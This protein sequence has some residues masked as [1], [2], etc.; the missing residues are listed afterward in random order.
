[1]AVLNS[2]IIYSELIEQK[3]YLPKY[4]LNLI[5][6]IL[7]AHL[8]LRI[9]PGRKVSD[10]NP[11]RHVARHYP[12][13]IIPSTDKKK[14]PQKKCHIHAITQLGLEM[15]CVKIQGTSV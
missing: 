15:K 9:L 11:N 7:E 13:I 10:D 2:E 12:S 14:N 5:H 4:R 6:Q 3:L 8:A 1:M